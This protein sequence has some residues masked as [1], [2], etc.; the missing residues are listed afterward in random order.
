MENV[1]EMGSMNIKKLALK[2]SIPMIMSMMAIALYGIVD[3]IFI[4][5]ISDEALEAVSLSIPIQAIITAIGLGTGIGVNSVL[6]RFLGEKNE[7]K[8]NK[9]IVYGIG[10][11]F[12]SWIIIVIASIL[13]LENFFVFFTEDLTLQRLG[14]QYMSIIGIFSIGTLYQILFEKILEAHGKAKM[15]MIVQ[16]SG[17]IINLILD[18]ILIFGLIGAPELGIKGA[19]IATV[20][21]QIFGMLIGIIY[22]VKHRIISKKSFADLKI[23]KDIIKT[24]L[25]I[26]IPTIILESVSSFITIYLNKIL[27]S[28]SDEAVETWG[29]YYQLQRFVIIIVYGL[30]YGMIP[31]VAYNWGAGNKER[32]KE[33]IKVF[34]KL[35]LQVT[36]IGELLFLIVPELL[37]SFFKVSQNVVDT[38]IPAFRILSIGFTFAGISLMLS[39]ISQAFANGT[40]SLIVNLSRKIILVV[41]L[42]MI[43]KNIFGIYSIWISF[44]IAEIIT[45]IIAII[46]YNNIRKNIIEKI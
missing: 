35:T 7:K 6:A 11:I 2:T 12:I 39:A 5:N 46:L 27:I 19:A 8:A 14:Y 31:I 22:I 41:P 13:G 15:S 10:L 20:T 24:I 4:S 29:L 17:T 21:G 25:K 16:F 42:I 32:V 23:E 43:L 37:L 33:A 45:M 3:T 18:P 36:V 1:N 30:N 34:L 44:T 38:A 26:G 28:F 9:V 40:Y